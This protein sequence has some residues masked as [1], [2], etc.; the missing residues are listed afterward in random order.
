MAP[1][2]TLGTKRKAGEEG[3]VPTIKRRTL[4]RKR[5]ARI[6]VINLDVDLKLREMEE[7]K[8]EDERYLLDMSFVKKAMI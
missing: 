2:K 7:E 4:A 1:K 6:S 3:E 5:T 8:K